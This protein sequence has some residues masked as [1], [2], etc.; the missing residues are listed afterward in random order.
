M[1]IFIQ[2]ITVIIGSMSLVFGAGKIF[3]LIFALAKIGFE[4]FVNYERTLDK[5]MAEMKSQQGKK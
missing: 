1:R 4:V 5:A 2:Q 3:I